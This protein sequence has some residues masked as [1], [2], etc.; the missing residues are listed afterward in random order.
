M[1]D[2]ALSVS[3]ACA[4]FAVGRWLGVRYEPGAPHY[5]MALFLAGF[6]VYLVWA[7]PVRLDPRWVS[8]TVGSYLGLSLGSFLRRLWGKEREAPAPSARSSYSRAGEPA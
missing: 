3:L 2:L 4:G 6:A 1:N 5:L 7:S 8:L